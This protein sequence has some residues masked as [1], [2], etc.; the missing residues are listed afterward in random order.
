MINEQFL[1]VLIIF[2]LGVTI[3][4]LWVGDSINFIFR[5]FVNIIDFHVL[6]A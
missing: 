4:L 3:Q 5:V 1:H 6:I 2:G